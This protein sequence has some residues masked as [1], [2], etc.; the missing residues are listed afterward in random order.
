[1]SQL[2]A[3]AISFSF[4]LLIWCLLTN[5]LSWLNL[6]IGAAIAVLLPRQRTY[7][8]SLQRL[9]F[10]FG[11]S[12]IAVPKA[13]TEALALITAT[14][15]HEEEAI[16]LPTNRAIPLLVFLDVFCITIT[17]FTIAIGLE[18]KGYSYRIHRL[19]PLRARYND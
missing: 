17:P 5:D 3:F 2:L 6:L 14:S 10:S 19:L 9:L 4:R 8:I 12:L 18:K 1:M 11:R 13:Y 7:S 16:A 15:L